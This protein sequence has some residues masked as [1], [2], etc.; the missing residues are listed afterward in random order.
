MARLRTL[1]THLRE[2]SARE[3]SQV[4]LHLG[5][6][7]ERH[8]VLDWNQRQVICI[9]VICALVFAMLA[10]EKSVM[11]NCQGMLSYF[12]IS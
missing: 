3:G 1:P 10:H 4:H 9:T 2:K 8:R 7:R 6:R 12:F 5:L 11:T